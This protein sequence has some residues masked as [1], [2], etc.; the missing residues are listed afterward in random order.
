MRTN[1]SIETLRK[2]LENW[3]GAGQPDKNTKTAMSEL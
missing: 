3:A 2:P 1:K